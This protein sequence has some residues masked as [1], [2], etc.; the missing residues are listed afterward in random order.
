MMHEVL[1]QYGKS[2][3]ETKYKDFIC[4]LVILSLGTD[5]FI[6]IERMFGKETP[7]K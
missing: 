2:H 1:Y 3:H 6:Y 4:T 7:G 5:T